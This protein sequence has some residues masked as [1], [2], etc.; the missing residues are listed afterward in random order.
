VRALTDTGMPVSDS[1]RHVWNYRR[2]FARHSR[3]DRRRYVS[4]REL[5]LVQVRE[6]EGSEVS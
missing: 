6:F 4:V 2:L 3:P 5:Q 1:R